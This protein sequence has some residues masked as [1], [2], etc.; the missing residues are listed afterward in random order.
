MYNELFTGRKYDK[1]GNAVEWWTQS[2][3]NKY[4]KLAQCFVDQYNSYLV[5][6]LE[7]SKAYVS[8]HAGHIG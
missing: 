6:G 7:D 8:N 1:D 4:E 2:T 3:I 5:P